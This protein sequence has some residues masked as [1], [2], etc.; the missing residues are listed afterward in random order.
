MYP[1]W[2]V[3]VMRLKLLADGETRARV[4]FFQREAL[5]G[6]LASLRARATALAQHS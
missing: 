6:L 4:R 1:L 5:R 3:Q 2:P